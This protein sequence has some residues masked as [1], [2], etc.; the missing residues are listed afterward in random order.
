MKIE[1]TVQYGREIEYVNADMPDG[2]RYR[3]GY[4]NVV[5]FAPE[6]CGDG[7]QVWYTDGY[8]TQYL[9]VAVDRESAIRKAEHALKYGAGGGIVNDGTN[10][11]TSYFMS[12][13]EP[14]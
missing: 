10:A 2:K 11:F 5:F 7:F 4:V 14:E 3:P 13:R 8:K 9:P 1:K 12:T 6:Q